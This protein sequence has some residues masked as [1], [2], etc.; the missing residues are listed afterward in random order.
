MKSFKNSI[1]G[2]QRAIEDK[3]SLCIGNGRVGQ[4]L[5]E[6]GSDERDEIRNEVRPSMASVIRSYVILRAQGAY[7][8]WGYSL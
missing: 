6:V 5:V 7:Q 4:S 3:T 1:E 2:S 8:L